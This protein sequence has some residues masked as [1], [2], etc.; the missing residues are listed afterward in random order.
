MLFKQ[1]LNSLPAPRI[2][3]ISSQ[4]RSVFAKKRLRWR[5]QRGK[6]DFFSHPIVRKIYGLESSENRGKS[7]CVIFPNPRLN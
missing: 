2:I 1:F 4:V 6:C 5:N 3:K 7:Y